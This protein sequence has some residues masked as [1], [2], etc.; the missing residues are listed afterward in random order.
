MNKTIKSRWVKAL[1]SG[2]YTQGTGYLKESQP[3]GTANHC[4]LGVLC[5]LYVDS[6]EGKRV[7]AKFTPAK[8][9]NGLYLV[10]NGKKH[11]TNLLPEPVATW[12]GI[13]CNVDAD[14]D[15][16]FGRKKQEVALSTLNDE[17]FGNKKAGFKTIARAIERAL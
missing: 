12:A 3:D 9:D 15:V 11:D 4:C 6:A 13:E 7:K 10:T 5:E 14:I 8:H 16:T 17:G 1:R 2:K